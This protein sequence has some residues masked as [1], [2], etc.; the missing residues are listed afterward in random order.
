MGRMLLLLVFILF[1]A[2]IA[3]LLAKMALTGSRGQDILAK[4]VGHMYFWSSGQPI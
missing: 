1:F 3:I 4:N 2:L